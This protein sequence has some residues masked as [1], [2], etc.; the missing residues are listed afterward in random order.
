MNKL[1]LTG[2]NLGRAFNSRCAR[3]YAMHL[4]C[5]SVKLP[6]LKLKTRAKELLGSLPL[7]IALPASSNQSSESE[8]LKKKLFRFQIKPAGLQI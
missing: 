8:I 2:L 5:Y 7:D 1:L 3:A 6:N 4:R